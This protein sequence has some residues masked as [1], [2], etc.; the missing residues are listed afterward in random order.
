LRPFLGYSALPRRDHP[1]GFS[2]ADGYLDVQRTV[3]SAAAEQRVSRR[4]TPCPHVELGGAY[5]KNGEM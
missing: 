1:L 2:S 4:C 5:P 3:G